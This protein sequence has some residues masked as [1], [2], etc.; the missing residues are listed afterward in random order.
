MIDGR[1]AVIMNESCWAIM[2]L[3]MQEERKEA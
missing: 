3:K 1:K 2:R